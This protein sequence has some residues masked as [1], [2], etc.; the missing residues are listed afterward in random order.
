[1][2]KKSIKP[3]GNHQSGYLGN[4]LKSYL[5]F[6]NDHRE[7]KEKE[8]NITVKIDD[9]YRKKQYTAVNQTQLRRYMRNSKKNKLNYH[10]YRKIF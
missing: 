4:T 3:I 10:V 6:M 7:K 9:L 5:F 2:K 8:R 1:M